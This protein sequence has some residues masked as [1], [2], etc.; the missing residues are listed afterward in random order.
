MTGLVPPQ[1]VAV[2]EGLVAVAAYEGRFRLGL[3]LYDHLPASATSTAPSSRTAGHAV[4]EE[5]GRNDRGLLV[6]NDGKNRLLILRLIARVE[7]GQEAVLMLVVEGF[8]GLLKKEK[9]K[10]FHLSSRIYFI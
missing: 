2:P 10:H 5:V 3:L 6:E 8:I 1:V 7:Q 9:K 4:L